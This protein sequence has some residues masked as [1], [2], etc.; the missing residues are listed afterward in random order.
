MAHRETLVT[1]VTSLLRAIDKV[2]G[3]GKLFRRGK[4]KPR[5]KR[6]LLI[7][8]ARIIP[9]RHHSG[10]DGKRF[11]YRVAKE[12]TQMAEWDCIVEQ[13]R[14]R[15]IVVVGSRIGKNFSAQGGNEKPAL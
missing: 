15:N 5:H 2:A 11:H 10:I 3:E 6:R 9:A 4:P 1:I 12:H 7:V 13:E 14:P 8:V